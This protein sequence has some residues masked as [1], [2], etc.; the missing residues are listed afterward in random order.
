[1]LYDEVSTA[2]KSSCNAKERTPTAGKVAINGSLETKISEES[3]DNATSER[4]TGV[5]I[6]N[7]TAKWYED[8]PGNTLTNVSMDVGPG[9]LVAIIGPVGSGK[10]HSVFK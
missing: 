5:K 10:V 4:M 9:K 3:E 1:M 2:V 6:I 8:L 7:M